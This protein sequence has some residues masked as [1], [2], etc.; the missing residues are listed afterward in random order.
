[1]F[2]KL[3]DTSI[4]IDRLSLICLSASNQVSSLPGP[5][6]GHTRQAHC[7]GSHS[8]HS[9]TDPKQKSWSPHGYARYS[10]HAHVLA[11]STD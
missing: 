11:S 7:T 5:D 6:V 2:A 9:G 4:V 1:M 8:T 3:P 10:V